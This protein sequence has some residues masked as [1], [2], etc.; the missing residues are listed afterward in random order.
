MSPQ[1]I[2]VLGAGTMGHGIAHAAVAAGFETRLFDVA[3]PVLDRGLVAIGDI[4]AKGVEL[5]KMTASDAEAIFGRL[6][7]G[8]RSRERIEGRRLRDRSRT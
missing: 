7:S 6:T 8:H 3:Q 1:R 5:G 4:V 2:A